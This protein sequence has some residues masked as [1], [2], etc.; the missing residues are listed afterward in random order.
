[1]LELA[2]GDRRMTRP[3]QAGAGRGGTASRRP[4]AGGAVEVEDRALPDLGVLLGLLAGG[5]G[6]LEHGEHALA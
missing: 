1:L 3:Q 6:L 2:G 5:L 4:A